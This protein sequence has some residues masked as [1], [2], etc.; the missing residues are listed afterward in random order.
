MLLVQVI[1]DYTLLHAEFPDNGDN[2][3]FFTDSEDPEG[4]TRLVIDVTDNGEKCA[5]MIL[6]LFNDMYDPIS[7]LSLA[8]SI[9]GF[10]GNLPYFVDVLLK[11]REYSRPGP[12]DTWSGVIDSLYVFPR[13]RRKGIASFILNN[14]RELLKKGTERVDPG[15]IVIC[16]EKCGEV[17]ESSEEGDNVLS[18]AGQFLKK[19]RYRNDRYNK[20]CWIRDY[21]TSLSVVK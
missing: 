15:C 4:V 10:G 13:H 16:P 12:E 9:G 21:R 5:Y 7:I 14:L 6:Y 17:Y 20:D 19:N 1:P 3:K 2:E 11:S 18:F 8:D